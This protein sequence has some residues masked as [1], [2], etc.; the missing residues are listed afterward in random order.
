[1]LAV[2]G[3]RSLSLT[4]IFAL[5]SMHPACCARTVMGRLSISRLEG[6]K[7]NRK[8]LSQRDQVELVNDRG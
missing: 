3:H 4:H 7:A 2:T 5:V 1:M 6:S 8:P